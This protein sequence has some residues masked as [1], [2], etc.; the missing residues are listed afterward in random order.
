MTHKHK[1][2]FVT[3][4]RKGRDVFI[5]DNYA[6]FVCDCGVYK[7]VPLVKEKS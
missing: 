3:T 5:P 4:F 2:Q 1:W 7:D 6:R